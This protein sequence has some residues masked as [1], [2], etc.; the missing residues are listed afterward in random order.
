VP[1]EERLSGGN[2]TPVVRVGQTVRRRPGPWTPA[3]HALLR[4]LEEA[5]FKAAP[6]V[7]G[8]D[9]E[10]REILSYLPGKVGS[11]P[12]S[13]RLSSDAVLAQAGRLLRALHDSTL[14]FTP[15]ADARWQFGVRQ[16][17][18]VVC[19]GDFAPHNLLFAGHRIVGVIDFDTAGPAPRSWDLAYTAYTWVPLGEF[20][21]EAR[22][23]SLAEQMRRLRLLAGAYGLADRASLSAALEERLAVLSE[24]IRSRAEAG[25]PAFAR[26]LAAGDADLYDVDRG[27]LARHRV[28]FRDALLSA[29]GAAEH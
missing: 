20:S 8:C 14:T 21:A 27:Y 26:M 29:G 28:E 18:E 16:P 15:P 7:L 9:E 10:G 22:R 23:T 1:P 4:H 12:L 25:D 13:R 6:R 19:H 17:A 5:G 11:Y 24:L 2:L 3:V